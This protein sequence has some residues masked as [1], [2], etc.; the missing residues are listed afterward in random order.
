[1]P[2]LRVAHVQV[3]HR[4]A[5]IE[6][7]CGCA[8]EFIGGQRKRG[9]VGLRLSPAV[10]RDRHDNSPLPQPQPPLPAFPPAPPRA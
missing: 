4:G 9:V 10:W 3:D 6:A 5:A 2:P 8:G 7:F 1:M